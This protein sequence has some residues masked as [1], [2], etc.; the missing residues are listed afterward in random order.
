MTSLCHGTL[1]SA[2]ALALAL[3]LESMALLTS[4]DIALLTGFNKSSI[5]CSIRP[6]FSHIFTFV[7]DH[8]WRWLTQSIY[9]DECSWRFTLF[10]S[11]DVV[12]RNTNLADNLIC[13][14]NVYT[15]S[16]VEIPYISRWVPDAKSLQNFGV[17]VE[18]L[19]TWVGFMLIAWGQY[20][21]SADLIDS[22]GK[23]CIKPANQ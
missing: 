10:R 8:W 20:R 19:S 14:V 16:L 1:A 5:R 12:C 6:T 21:F 3:A 22:S 7:Y 4:L 17:F 13:V 9:T 18:P 15:C 2:S 11:C 23:R